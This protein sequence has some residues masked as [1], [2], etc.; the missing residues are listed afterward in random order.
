[1]N[2]AHWIVQ[3]PKQATHIL[4]FTNHMSYVMP[5][6]RLWTKGFIPPPY[7]TS[8]PI[9]T[10]AWWVCQTLHNN[11]L[12]NKKYCIEVHEYVHRWIQIQTEL[13]KYLEAASSANLDEEK[14]NILG[15]MKR[16][17]CEGSS[18]LSPIC[19]PAG[20]AEVSHSMTPLSYKGLFPKDIVPGQIVITAMR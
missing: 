1:M 5:N 18:L 17:C 15:Y 3:L 8:A 16:R 13:H 11:S 12:L 2:T 4:P 14:D 9:R 10:E 19:S 6:F 20:E 7:P